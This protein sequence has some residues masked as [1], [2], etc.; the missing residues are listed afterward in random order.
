[1]RDADHEQLLV[2]VARVFSALGEP[3][4]LRILCALVKGEQAVNGIGAAVGATQTSVSRHLQ[5]LRHARL[6]SRRRDGAHVLYRVASPM[7][8]LLCRRIAAS[9]AADAADR[10]PVD[11][12]RSVFPARRISTPGRHPM[13]S[14]ARKV[15]SLK[16][17]TRAGA[18][19]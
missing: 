3:A 13:P 5:V 9:L 11:V 4:R 7:V 15:A 19:R 2:R 18:R 8:A 6:V 16:P 1:M 17:R 10:L 12:L 14:D